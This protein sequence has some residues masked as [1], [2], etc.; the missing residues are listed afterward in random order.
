MSNLKP[1]FS[2]YATNINHLINE[3]FE[4]MKK[5]HFLIENKT[6]DGKTFDTETYFFKLFE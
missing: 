2:V 6:F 1:A 3:N 4:F 5:Y